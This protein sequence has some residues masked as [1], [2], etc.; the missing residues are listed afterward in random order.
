MRRAICPS[1]RRGPLGG[2]ATA[3]GGGSASGGGSTYCGST[4]ATC[5]GGAA[6]HADRASAKNNELIRMVS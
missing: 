6:A 5:G 2:R 1:E 4:R 3:G